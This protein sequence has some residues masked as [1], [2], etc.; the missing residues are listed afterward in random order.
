MRSFVSVFI[1]EY[2]RVRER[3][4]YA[5]GAD[6]REGCRC[7]TRAYMYVCMCNCTWTSLMQLTPLFIE[8]RM[9]MLHTIT[10][11]RYNSGL[12]SQRDYKQT[13]EGGG[14]EQRDRKRDR[15]GGENALNNC[16]LTYWLDS[17]SFRFS[18][19]NNVWIF[20]DQM[21]LRMVIIKLWK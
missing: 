14:R 16:S 5:R 13:C 18:L 6:G 8:R 12:D 1:S 4:R 17:P 11:N 15:Q 7:L 19:G 10:I 2:E 9:C 21:W 20:S 3:E